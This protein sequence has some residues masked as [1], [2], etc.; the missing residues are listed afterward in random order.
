MNQNMPAVDNKNWLGTSQLSSSNMCLCF[1]S[2]IDS[3]S[4]HSQFS[5][6]FCL[7]DQVRSTVWDRWTAQGNSYLQ[8]L[9]HLL[10]GGDF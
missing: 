6:Y 7:T 1:D 9:S 10:P 3:L 8:V 4:L 5:G 2:Y